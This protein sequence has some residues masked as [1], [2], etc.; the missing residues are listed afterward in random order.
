MFIDIC[1]EKINITKIATISKYEDKFIR[2]TKLS[3]GAILEE[4]ESEEARDADF[5][6]VNE[7][8]A[9]K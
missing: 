4:Y 7:A 2:Y 3:G 6:K 9:A 5:I 1:G 8:L